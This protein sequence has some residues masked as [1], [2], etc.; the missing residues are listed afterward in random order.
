MIEKSFCLVLKGCVSSS[1]ASN[2]GK[3]K[4]NGLKNYVLQNFCCEI[5]NFRKFGKL[6]AKELR[7]HHPVI[8]FY[9]YILKTE[10][11]NT[12]VHI[13]KNLTRKNFSSKITKKCEYKQQKSVYY[14]R[15]FKPR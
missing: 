1:Q 10:K 9:L 3:M 4:Q 7:S 13:L 12:F 14:S 6:L 15:N 11:T 2:P 5:L 8:I